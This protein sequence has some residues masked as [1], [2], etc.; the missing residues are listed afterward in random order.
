MN[1]RPLFWAV[2]CFAFGEV[3]YMFADEGKQI[4]T[5]VAVLICVVAIIIGLKLPAKY[6]AIY[7]AFVFAGVVRLWWEDVTYPGAVLYGDSVYE[8]YEEYYEGYTV[9]GSREDSGEE[10]SG[11]CNINGIG[12]VD[13]IAQGGSGY[14]LTISL[15]K[16]DTGRAVIYKEIKVIVYGVGFQLDVGDRV[17]LSGRINAF[18][19]SGNPGEFDRT[20]YY[21]AREIV[22]YATGSSMEL[23]VLEKTAV[24]LEPCEELWYMLKGCLYTARVYFAERLN[25][26][27][28]PDIAT[29]YSGILLGE[30]S[31]IPEENML[32]YRLCG[33]AHIFAISGLHISIV[34]GLLYKAMRKL[35]TSFF[36]G[37][38]VAMIITL[39]YS[40]MTGFNFST[41]RAVIMLALSLGG[42]VLG[43]RYDIITGMALALLLLLISQPY[44][45]MD[46]GL[47]LSFGAVAGVA[48]SK[49][50]IKVLEES[51]SF[52]RLKKKKTRRLYSVLS[53]IIFSMGISLITT[54]LIAYM[55]YQIPLYSTLINII[56]VPIMSMTVFCGFM[57]LLVSVISISVGGLVIWPGALSLK[58]Y[59]LLCSLI[60]KLPGSVIN[61]GRP[62]IMH[63]VLYY[64][65]LLVVLVLAN[66]GNI[67]KLRRYIK[68]KT[69]KWFAYG[70]IRL[71][72]NALMVCLIA[73]IGAFIGV[74]RY[75]NRGNYIL[76]LNVGQ[77]DGVLIRTERG[78]NMVIDVGS[79][80]NDSLGEYVALPG[81]LAQGMGHIDYWFITHLDR[82]HTS[83]LM[84]ILQS[85]VDLGIS[86][87]NLVLGEHSVPE[88][89]YP[90]LLAL[91][92]DK[93]I[94]IIYMKTGDCI[95]DGEFYMTA[96]HPSSE[97]DVEDRNEQSLV[98][99]YKVG[100]FGA[101]FTGDI[102][103]EAVDSILETGNL[104]LKEYD[105]IK[106]PHHGSKYSSSKEFIERVN[107][108][109]AIISCGA[110]NMY[111]H[112]HDE[113]L[114]L[115]E[116]SSVQ[117]Y[118]TDRVGAIAIE[119]H[120]N[121]EK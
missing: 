89:A 39:L 92:L 99:E 19:P 73:L 36:A 121:T 26:I 29:T 119:I 94:N 5:A 45:L 52:G 56:I 91:A 64:V 77:G 90:E 49:Y 54:P 47:L 87:D 30:K 68:K 32:L 55:Y 40:L 120:G 58:L 35:G 75:L 17:E 107:P 50:I 95:S 116:E 14:S 11:S 106:I 74:H 80:S 34:G 81:L 117:V 78:V 46:G 85:E 108:T 118:R 48:V 28:E 10:N 33:I 60:M 59:Q 7:V 97:F 76:F 102:G 43:R 114:R 98:M 103:M 3:M 2:M 15:R 83:G 57:A 93:N 20:A 1:K 22:G 63:T 105:V 13:R 62:H 41:I 6:K 16:T 86:V 79:T 18:V 31:G 66:P 96:V 61:T 12:I 70:K 110:Y 21:R 101:L 25:L 100:A 115:L 113:T 42:E 111:G 24:T 84:H 104:S 112:P 82:D 27:A 72:A 69:G 8:S 37:A 65:A 38:T 88:R 23:Q 4:G 53:S 9:Y 44:R 71:A 51:T 109:V 67:S